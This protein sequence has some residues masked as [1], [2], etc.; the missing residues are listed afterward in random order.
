[1]ERHVRGL[2]VVV[3]VSVTALI[4]ALLLLIPPPLWSESFWQIILLAPFG[5][6]F[7]LPMLALILTTL[8]SRMQ[9]AA[10]QLAML[11]LTN[12]SNTE[13]AEVYAALASRRLQLLTDV[14]A[15]LLP[16]LLISIA[17]T[18]AKPS[19][20]SNCTSLGLCPTLIGDLLIGLVIAL[21]VAAVIF[22]TTAMLYRSAVYAGV[23]MTFLWHGSAVAAAGVCTLITGA[24][25]IACTLI[26]LRNL[27][28]LISPL[29]VCSCVTM[30]L[31]GFSLLLEQYVRFGAAAALED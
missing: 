31:L 28:H 11:R 26:A 4:L 13:I 3:S 21:P 29:P 16:T 22:V 30:L 2:I 18:G 23:W 5:M 12:I 9:P 24:L 20:P 7:L 14:G 17:L 27:P 1:M 25:F 8:F 19:I 15:G 10:D 6:I